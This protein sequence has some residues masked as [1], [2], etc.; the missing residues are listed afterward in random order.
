AVVEHDLPRELRVRDLGETRLPGLDRPEAV[1][2]IVADGLA[3][4]FPPIGA[5]RPS[6]APQRPAGPILLERE[7]EIAALHAHADAAAPG[8]GRLV[9]IEG[10][11]GIGKS[12]LL[13][14]ARALAGESGLVLL[15][16][17]GGELE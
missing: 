7:A 14:E 11:A 1:F 2:Q 13:A 10:R 15:N 4:R 5:R 17:R 6:A 8:A 12:R 3:D 9:A 16:A